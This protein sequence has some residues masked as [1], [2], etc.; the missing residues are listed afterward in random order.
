MGCMSVKDENFPRAQGVLRGK[1]IASLSLVGRAAVTSGR[2]RHA[3]GPGPEGW[4]HEAIDGLQPD[5]LSRE[6]TRWLVFPRS[7]SDWCPLLPFSFLV[8]RVPLR[9]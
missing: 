5:S 8:G 3:T 9:K 4:V 7:P 1:I 6:R 2:N